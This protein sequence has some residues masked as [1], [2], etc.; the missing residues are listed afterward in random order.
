MHPSTKRLLDAAREA[1]RESAAPVHTWADLAR[2][3]GESPQ[4]ISN[5]KQRGLSKDGAIKAER[6]YAVSV[7]H[8]LT[9]AGKSAEKAPLQAQLMSLSAR[10][11]VPLQLRWEELLPMEET[12]EEFQVALPD[13]A[14]APE[15]KAGWLVQFDSRQ[16][17][18]FGN[19]ILVRDRT[20]TLHFRR[21]RQ[22]VGMWLARPDNEN[23][24]TLESE[25]D[26]LEIL[27]VAKFVLKPWE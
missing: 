12:P 13:D 8:L 6:L 27:A 7:D 25:R 20:G 5:W 11:V 26:G 1:T 17:P 16:E 3:M 19:G 21:Y 18:K 10:T 2:H 9:G 22:G 14:M 4:T 15:A 23:F 24:V